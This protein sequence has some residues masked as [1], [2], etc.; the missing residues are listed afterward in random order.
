MLLNGIDK[1]SLIIFLFLLF[2]YM[3][4]IQGSRERKIYE[5]SNN[6]DNFSVYTYGLKWF[7]PFSQHEQESY[8]GVT[9]F[10]QTEYRT[11]FRAFLLGR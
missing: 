3:G 1:G 9:V 11:I 10:G 7:R 4:N 2:P 6:S 5:N 8:M